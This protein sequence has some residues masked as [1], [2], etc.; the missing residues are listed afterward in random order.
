MN[1]KNHQPIKITP[2]LYQ[3]GLHDFP[4]YLS[5]GKEGMLIEGGTSA[6]SDI[7]VKQIKML[8]FDPLK[9]TYMVLPH[10]HPDHVGAV[11]RIRELWPHLKIVAGTVAAKFL[12]KES[13]VKRFL[14]TDDFIVDLLMEREEIEK[15]PSALNVYKF[16]ADQIVKEGDKIELGDGVVWQVYETPGHCPDHIALFEEKEKTLTIGDIAGFFDP[17]E[18]AFWPNYFTSLEDYCNSIRKIAALPAKRGL[19]SHNGV[20]D[21]NVKEFLEKALKATE[22]FHKELLS[23]LDKGED[24]K[25]IATEKTDW[26]CSFG[27]LASYEAIVN[28][29][30]LLMNVSLAEREKD[31][32]FFP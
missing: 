28:L 17:D 18:K 22:A 1:E 30:E 19:L 10:T 14:P 3:L 15:R 20:I 8:G 6:T 16:E 13:F 26:V 4:A 23:R 2:H 21:R 12:A 24:R 31:L 32:F 27:P 5:I 25:K 9:I 11:P 29:N 7:I